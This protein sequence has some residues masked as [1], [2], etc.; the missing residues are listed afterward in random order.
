MFCDY[1]D[2]LLTNEILKSQQR[3]KS[4]V[5]TVYTEEVNTISLISNDDKRLETF[6]RINSY[7]YGASVRKVCKTDLL[8]KYK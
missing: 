4:E 1:T 2:C 8:S 7:P 6:E 5:H 3:F